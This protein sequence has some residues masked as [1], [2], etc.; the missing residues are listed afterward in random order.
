MR[1]KVKYVEWR[2]LSYEGM[3]SGMHHTG[4]FGYE[5]DVYA[6]TYPDQDGDVYSINITDEA[7]EYEGQQRITNRMVNKINNE[8]HNVWVNFYYDEYS[9]EYCLDGDLNDYI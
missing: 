7:K 4:I 8:L 2:R 3:S 1:G 5:S 6:V 9:G